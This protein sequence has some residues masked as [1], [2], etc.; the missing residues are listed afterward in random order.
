MTHGARAKAPRVKPAQQ[1]GRAAQVDALARR[2]YLSSTPDTLRMTI[3]QGPDQL[4]GALSAQQALA[5]SPAAPLT[6]F[7]G[8]RRLI[9]LQTE[10]DAVGVL[11]VRA[12]DLAA[13]FVRRV[14]GLDAVAQSTAN[15]L[16][17]SQDALH[18]NTGRTGRTHRRRTPSRRDNPPRR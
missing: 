6:W 9:Q 16:V 15:E 2:L 13:A 8:P 11:Q 1:A 3:S 7:V 5:M 18:E 12:H 10:R 14:Q 17:A 4:L